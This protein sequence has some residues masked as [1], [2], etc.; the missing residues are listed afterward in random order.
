MN[1]RLR[2]QPPVRSPIPTA[3]LFAPLRTH[4]PR[5]ALA[6]RLRAAFDVHR[7]VLTDS[8]TSALAF[9]MRA[10]TTRREGVCL[11]PGYGCYD[12][13]SAAL[14]AGV[15]VALYDLDPRT[16]L[17]DHTSLGRLLDA[18]VA[19]VV[20][21]H[22]FGIPV[23]VADIIERCTAAGAVLIDDAAQAAGARLGRGRAGALGDLGVLSFGRGKGVTGGGGGALLVRDAAG[24]WSNANDALGQSPEQPWRATVTLLAQWALARPALYG[25]PSRLPWLRLGE[26]VFR[27]PSAPRAMSKESARILEHTLGTMDAEAATRRVNAARLH[28]AAQQS[29]LAIG[30][31]PER[32]ASG[33]WLRFPVVLPP[34]VGAPPPAVRALG[35]V[36]GYPVA[37]SSLAQ[38]QPSLA[39]PGALPGSEELARQLW[40]FPTH[41]GLS[42][43]DVSALES[44]LTR[45]RGATR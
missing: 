11:L 41:G 14:A 25:I 35:V 29:G 34:G 30:V 1:L 27:A 33:G 22:P 7:V 32:F 36:R 44:W 17:P 26:T 6:E 9:A 3:A 5:Q 8:G 24:R 42:E 16:L 21:V 45:V 28:A 18:G 31:D 19:A 13:A 39:T 2:R 20:V 12:L 37:L 23:P 4:D 10:A 38:L 15:R 40:T 43:H